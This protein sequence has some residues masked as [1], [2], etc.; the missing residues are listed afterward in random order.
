[1][2]V[3]RDTECGGMRFG[4]SCRDDHEQAL[5][6]RGYLRICGVD[7]V[8]RGPL[9]GPVVAAAVVL[10][11]P[12]PIAGIN[13]SKQ[14]SEG[15]REALYDEIMQAAV[16][17]GVGIVDHDT[18]DQI[19]ILQATRRAMREAVAQIRPPPDYLL[20][21]ALTLSGLPIPQEGIIHGDAL[22]VSIAAASIIAKVTRDR[23]MRM[24]HDRWPQYDFARHKGY[25]TQAHLDAI[26]QHGPSPI[27]RMTFRGV[28][29]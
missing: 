14:L 26:R 29:K 16:A 8:G 2:E 20:I 15:R 27:H 18:I 23:Q 22:S 9:A 12:C 24:Y 21:D 11:L 17:I 10:P 1:M 28:L 19:N 7:E 25:G 6:A 4:Q 5:A 13:D 3:G